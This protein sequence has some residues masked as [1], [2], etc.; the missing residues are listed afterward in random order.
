MLLK[1]YR[2]RHRRWRGP[3]GEIDLVLERG[4]IVVFVE[5]KTRSSVSFGGAAAAVDRDKRERIVRAASAYLSRFGLWES[6]SRFDVVTLEK[7]DGP[8]PW[9]IRHW[10]GAFRADCGRLL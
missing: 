8:W 2:L 7:K 4:G 5:V 1:G 6:P 10:E 3:G 9:R